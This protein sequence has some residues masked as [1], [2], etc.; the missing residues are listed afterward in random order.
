MINR[1]SLLRTLGYSSV[2][3]SVPALM[4]AFSFAH[5][6]D[7][8]RI[9][10]DDNEWFDRMSLLQYSILSAGETEDPG[11]SRLNN[12][13]RD[14]SYSCLGCDLPLFNA[15]QKYDSKTGW[16]SF[17]DCIDG[18][19]ELRRSSF[20]LN[21]LAPTEYHCASCGGH[22]GHVFNDGPE[23]TGKRYCSNGAVLVFSPA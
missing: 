6:D 2:V 20:S 17:W 14:G 12:E 1:R 23:P 18:H 5:P 10:V 21:Q 9:I 13:T 11:S 8:K 19:V 16:P 4:P 7:V 22:H 15:A 3:V